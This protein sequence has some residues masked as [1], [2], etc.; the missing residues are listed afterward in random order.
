[1]VQPDF[2]VVAEL[3]VYVLFGAC[4]RHASRQGAYRALELVFAAVYGLVLEWF[5]IKQLRAYQYGPFLLMIDGAPLAVALAWAAIIYSSMELSDRIELPEPVRPVLDALLALNVDLAVDFTAIRVGLWRWNGVS[6]DQQWFGVPWENFWAWFIVVWS[7]SGFVRALRGWRD[8][9]MWRWLY[10]PVAAV[11][12]LA[13]LLVA[14]QVYRLVSN[15]G[16]QGMI[17]PL[18]LIGCGVLVVADSRPRILRPGPPEP[19]IIAVPV[20]FHL[21][22]I[23]AGFGFGLYA[24]QPILADIGIGMLAIALIVHLWPWWVYRT[25]T[26]T[27]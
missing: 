4:L 5:T 24:Q 21:L 1:M 7:Y 15:P 27:A 13:V 11:L 3:A 12:S 26:A 2:I 20:I 17:G 23:G 22:S 14:N 10:A 18:A 8:R 16:D 9:P 6:P 19:A 25:K